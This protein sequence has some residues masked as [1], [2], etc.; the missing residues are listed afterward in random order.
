MWDQVVFEILHPGD[1]SGSEN[2]LNRLWYAGAYTVLVMAFWQ[3]W[4]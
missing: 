3:R 2:D 4:A 1:A